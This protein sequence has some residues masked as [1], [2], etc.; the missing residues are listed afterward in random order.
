MDFDNI[1]LI[2]KRVRRLE[3]TFI[4]VL[5]FF[6]LLLMLFN[7]ETRPSISNFVYSVQNW[8]FYLFFFSGAFLFAFNGLIFKKH[9]YNILLS[10]TLLFIAI[11][12]HLEYPI[13]HFTAAGLFY[14]GSVAAMIAFSS[15]Q[16]RL[17]KILFGVFTLFGLLGHFA[18]DF[19]NLFVAEWIG[20]LPICVHF[21]LESQNKI[22]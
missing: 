3:I 1:S 15:P 18:F 6:P 19:Y 13:I 21:Q 14:V 16:Q 7:W 5:F 9:N 8:I 22:D 12:K 2:E 17:L 11:F 4:R 20:L 10:V